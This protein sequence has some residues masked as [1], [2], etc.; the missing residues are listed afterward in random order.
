MERRMD[1]IGHYEFKAMLKPHIWLQQTPDNTWRSDIAMNSEA[2]WETWFG[3]YT[4]YMLMY[5]SMA[6]QLGFEMLCVG[7]ELHSTVAQQPER[8][9][10]LIGQIKEA[11]SGKLVYAANWSDD[12]NEV[13]FW[14][15]MDYIGIQ[16]YYP[17]AEN[18]NPELEELEAGWA[19]HATDLQELS[20]RYNKPILFTEIGYKSTTDAAT[21]PWEWVQPSHRFYKK[22]SHKTQALSYQAFFNVIWPEPW[23]AGAI[24]WQWNPGSNSDGRNNRF[25]IKGKPALNVVAGGFGRPMYP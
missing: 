21:R 8:W 10:A 3:F 22:V 20:E 18:N 23:F 2:E 15:D 6:E 4:E 16:A 25:T 13:S 9:K 11:Y 5:A 12:L 17:I 14:E 19:S 7:T 1:M 24:L